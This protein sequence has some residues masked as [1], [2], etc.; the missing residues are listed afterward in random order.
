M[1]ILETIVS[2]TTFTIVLLNFVFNIYAYYKTSFKFSENIKAFKFA[3]SSRRS[4]SISADT[5][6]GLGI[7]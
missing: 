1:P 7:R 3:P 4:R 2:H 6:I 5:S